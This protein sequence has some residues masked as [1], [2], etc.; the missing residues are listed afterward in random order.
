MPELFEAIMVISFG[1]SWPISIAKSYTSRTAKG[2]S[3]AF[4]FLILFGYVCGIISKI[5]ADNITYVFI[6][7]VLN[8]VLVSIDLILYFRNTKLDKQ[9]SK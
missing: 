7:Y 4:L 1:V 6:F 2:K 3:V 9:S 8:L 5:L